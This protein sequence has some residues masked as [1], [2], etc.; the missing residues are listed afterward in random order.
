MVAAMTRRDAPADPDQEHRF[1]RALLRGRHAD[2][3]QDRHGHRRRSR[4]GRDPCRAGSLRAAA[5][6]GGGERAASARCIPSRARSS[7]RRGARD[8]QVA[9]PDDLQERPGLGVVAQS[10]SERAVLGRRALLE[11]LGESPRT[12]RGGDDA[13]GVWVALGGRCLGR[14]VLRDH[15]AREARE[16]LAA[17]RAL[18]IDRLLL[19]TGDRADVAREVGD[20]LGM[21]EVDRRGAARA[22]ARGGARRAG[23]GPHRDDGRRRRERRA[24]ARAARTSA[25]RSAPR[26]TRSRSAART[27]PC[28]GRTSADCRG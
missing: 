28:S 1:P 8:R 26:S 27:S 7:P 10:R 13:A 12:T 6:R 22:E 17:M 4:G 20:A 11:E 16:A 5:A 24:R 18:G 15:R 9:P 21:D 23:S 19:L 14:L 3:R 25:S 2:P